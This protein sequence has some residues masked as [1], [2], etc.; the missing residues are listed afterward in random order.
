MRRLWFGQM[1]RLAHVAERIAFVRMIKIMQMRI[2]RI[3]GHFLED[4]EREKYVS[5]QG[6]TRNNDWYL[7]I[8]RFNTMKM[9]RWTFDGGSTWIHSMVRMMVFIR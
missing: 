2:A 5:L 3:L 7:M 6:K 1:H 4:E 8:L 9:N